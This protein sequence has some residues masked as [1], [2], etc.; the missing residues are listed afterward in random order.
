MD[1]SL[2]VP[3]TLLY[4]SSSSPRKDGIIWRNAGRGFDINSLLLPHSLFEGNRFP[5][6]HSKRNVPLGC[7]FQCGLFRE[8]VYSPDSTIPKSCIFIDH[9]S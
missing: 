5:K 2:V 6:F 9:K 8:I 3:K 7:R 1:V 4:K